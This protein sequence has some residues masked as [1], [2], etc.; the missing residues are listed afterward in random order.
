MLRDY[1]IAVL[2]G[3]SGLSSHQ[4]M[5]LKETMRTVVENTN[6]SILVVPGYGAGKAQVDPY[7]KE[8]GKGP[9]QLIVK[10]FS[11][12]VGPCTIA[13]WLQDLGCDQ[14]VAYPGIQHEN[15][16]KCR[17]WAVGRLLGKSGIH[18]TTALPWIKQSG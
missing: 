15:I 18:V 5:H 3:P 9:V 2:V 4:R 16:Y 11:K 17:V 13:Q 8:H 12:T 14:Y 6:N 7:L 10:G 1:K